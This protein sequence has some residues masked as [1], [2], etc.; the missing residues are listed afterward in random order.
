MNTSFYH[1]YNVRTKLGVLSCLYLSQGLPFG[2]FS[3][4]LPPLLRSYGVDLE[5]IGFISFL[6]FP[7]ALKFLWAPYVDQYGS[8]KLGRRKSWILFLRENKKVKAW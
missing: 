6:F 4:A 2:F 1:Q 7:W 5:V 8:Q 3:Q